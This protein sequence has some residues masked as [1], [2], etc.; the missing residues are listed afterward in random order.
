VATF[1]RRHVRASIQRD[2]STSLDSLQTTLDADTAQERTLLLRA[3]SQELGATREAVLEAAMRRLELSQKSAHQAYELA[4]QFEPNPRSIWGYV[5][6]LTRL[7]QFT[8]YQDERFTLD[9][10]ASRLLATLQ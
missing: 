6:G 7:S 3:S 5:Q 2:W 10:A 8:P 4:E 9:R 1:R